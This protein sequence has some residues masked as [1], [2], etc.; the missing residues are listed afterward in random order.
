MIKWTGWR[1][2]DKSDLPK[3]L[4]TDGGKAAVAFGWKK[5]WLHFLSEQRKLK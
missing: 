4:E 2:R 1:M 3:R 5:E